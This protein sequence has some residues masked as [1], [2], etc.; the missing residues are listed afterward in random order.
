MEWLK[1]KFK[2]L[3]IS[4]VVALLAYMLWWSLGEAAFYVIPVV[5]AVAILMPWLEQKIKSAKK[6]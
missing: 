1:D 5:V 2:L 3:A 6:H 4:T